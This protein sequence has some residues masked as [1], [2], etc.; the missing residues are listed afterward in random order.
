MKKLSTFICACFFTLALQAQDLSKLI[1]D[2]CNTVIKLNIE[3]IAALPQFKSLLESNKNAELDELVKMGL[4]P[5]NVSALTIALNTTKAANNPDAFRTN[6][7]AL[8]LLSTKSGFDYDAAIAKAKA[9]D[10]SGSKISELVF[11]GSKIT[12]VKKEGSDFGI[13]KLNNSTIVMGGAEIIKK[14][15]LLQKEKSTKSIATNSELTA[16]LKNNTQMVSI[17]GLFPKLPEKLISHPLMKEVKSLSITADL[18]EGLVLNSSI[19]CKTEDAAGQINALMSMVV[20]MALSQ[21][22]SPLKMKSVKMG[23]EKTKVFLNVKLT[24]EELTQ[25]ITPLMMQMMMGK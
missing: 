2:S 5:E 20:G 7:D 9:K 3:K 13:A 4:G 19:V 25:M 14:A 8:L 1:P 15:L 21:E 6:P 18:I 23:Q 17:H 24:P 16:L 11:E 10:E 22:T 12:L